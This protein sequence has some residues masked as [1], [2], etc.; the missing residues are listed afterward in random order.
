MVPVGYNQLVQV[1]Q[2]RDY[3]V[4]HTEIVH[5]A[6]IIPLDGRPHL[7]QHIRPWSGDS[8]GHW[9]GQTLVVETTNFNDKTWNQFN[10]W[11]V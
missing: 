3:V 6:R 2:T 1:I 5:D 10:K 4:L 8:R 11:N 7:P 9:E